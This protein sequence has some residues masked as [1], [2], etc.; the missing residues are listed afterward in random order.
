MCCC[1]LLPPQSVSPTLFHMPQWC[2]HG[3]V[4][5]IPANDC[6]IF[7][8]LLYWEQLE[9]NREWVMH[10]T[11]FSKFVM[12]LW[13]LCAAV[14]S[15]LPSQSVSPTPFHMPQWCLLYWLFLLTSLMFTLLFTSPWEH[16]EHNSLWVTHLSSTI[17]M[18]YM[19]AICCCFL[20]SPTSEGKSHSFPYP[21]MI[22]AVSVILANDYCGV[23]PRNWVHLEHN[24]EWVT[25]PHIF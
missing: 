14:L 2:V 15:F 24:R 8:P 20:F 16:L 10:S 22:C 19:V 6:R 9:Y 4:L 11:S 7:F 1:F 12:W 21:S 3:A 17:V 5:V 18:W 23:C 25:N 13:L